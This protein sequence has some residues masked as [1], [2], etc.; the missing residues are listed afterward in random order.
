MLCETIEGN[1]AVSLQ[2][3]G[4]WMSDKW[5]LLAGFGFA[6]ANTTVG[7]SSGCSNCFLRIDFRARNGL[8]RILSRWV[9]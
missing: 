1:T 3:V 7:I 8:L 6:A 5:L 4:E 9:Y 2:V